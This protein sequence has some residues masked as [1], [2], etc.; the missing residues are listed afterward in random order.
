MSNNNQKIKTIKEESSENMN[1]NSSISD[2]INLSI[3]KLREKRNNFN[4]KAVK[5]N[6]NVVRKSD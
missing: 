6:G 2:R 4:D 5:Y 1:E 3:H